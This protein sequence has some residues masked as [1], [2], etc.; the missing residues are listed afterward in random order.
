MLTHA[1]NSTRNAIQLCPD[2]FKAGIH[3]DNNQKDALECE[4]SF[5]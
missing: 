3:F 1:E 4:I 5:S 2:E